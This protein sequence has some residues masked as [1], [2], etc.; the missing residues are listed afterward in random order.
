MSKIKLALPFW[1]IGP[2]GQWL[3]SIALSGQESRQRTKFLELL[4]PTGREIEKK[5]LDMLEDYAEKD[6]LGLPRKKMKMDPA[7]QKER[8]H[9]DLTEE[10]EKKFQKE[11]E[12]YL[13]SEC[14]ISVDDGNMEKVKVVRDIILNTRHEFRGEA[15][16]MYDAWC[17]AFESLPKK[18][19][20]DESEETK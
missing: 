20:Y 7:I 15:A 13:K 9:Y 2:L 11:F 6:T 10:S 4:A 17:E 16:A 5:R 12:I 18:L 19:N 14:I 1:C 8:E 3:Q